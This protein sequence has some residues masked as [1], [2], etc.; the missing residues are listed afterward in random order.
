MITLLVNVVRKRPRKK[1]G[2]GEAGGAV[3]KPPKKKQKPEGMFVPYTTCVP[4][5][6]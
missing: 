4:Y 1:S 6:Y 3:K 5:W 2:N